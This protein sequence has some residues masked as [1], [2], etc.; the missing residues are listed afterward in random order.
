MAWLLEKVRVAVMLIAAVPKIASQKVGQNIKEQ[1]AQRNFS[2]AELARQMTDSG[3]EIE[4]SQVSKIE[5]GHAGISVERLLAFA[6]VLDVNPLVLLREPGWSKFPWS[7]A[8]D[9]QVVVQ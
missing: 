4:R 1:R 8:I 5:H 9:G 2:V 3:H 6:A 7:S